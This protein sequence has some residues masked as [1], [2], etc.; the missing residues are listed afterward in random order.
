[1]IKIPVLAP[2]ITDKEKQYVSMAM[3][4]GWVGSKGTFIDG[5]EEKFAKFIGVDHAI[6][7]SSGTTALQLALMAIG[8]RPEH[9]VHVPKNTFIATKNMALLSTTKVIEHEHDDTWNMP[10][11]ELKNAKPGVILG[12]HLYGNPLDL[13]KWDMKRHLLIE[14]CAQALG[15]KYRGKRL[16]SFG[17]VST[18]SLHSAKMVTT[19]EGGMVCTDDANVA[20]AVRQLKNHCMQ[21]PYEHRGLG[22]NFRMTNIQAAMG[23]AQ[24]E[25]INELMEKKNEITKFYDKNLSDKFIRQKQTGGSEVV[26]YL[27]V[28][29]HD[30]AANIALKLGDMGIETR[31]GF[32]SNDFIGLPSSTT[33]TNSEL[34]YVVDAANSLA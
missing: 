18:F 16:G 8:I 2:D 29:R 4:S 31:P 22:F 5:L 7:C 25:R 13:G 6:T 20:S 19:G 12:V 30:N 28:Y 3:A 26:K 10:I 11:K 24:M 1:M 14:D 17:E 9:E 27:N 32:I 21:R 33:L 23:L 34:K 15:S